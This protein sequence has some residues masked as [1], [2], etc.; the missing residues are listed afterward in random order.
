VNGMGIATEMDLNDVVDEEDMN[1][2]DN[3]TFKE[4]PKPRISG[5]RLHWTRDGKR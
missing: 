1:M 2:N 5:L 3:Y 4:L